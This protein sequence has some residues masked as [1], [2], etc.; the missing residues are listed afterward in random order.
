VPCPAC[1]MLG[2]G[3][4]L[5][6]GPCRHGSDISRVVPC[7][8]TTGRAIYIPRCGQAR[9][10]ERGPVTSHQFPSGATTGHATFPPLG[11]RGHA[12]RI[13]FIGLAAHAL[14]AHRQAA[15]A[16]RARRRRK[17]V[18]TLDEPINDR[19]RRRS[20]AE[21]LIYYPDLLIPSVR[22]HLHA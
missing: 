19:A 16:F 20:L 17:L 9:L 2:P 10:R 7:S 3:T 18:W 4:A 12:A 1:L 13:L 14:F 22:L 11:V 21:L 6:I 15:D 8:I 5:P